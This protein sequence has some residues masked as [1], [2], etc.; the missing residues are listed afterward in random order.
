M[1]AKEVRP[2]DARAQT[3]P[4][5]QPLGTLSDGLV[6]QPKKTSVSEPET[7]GCR[8]L[9]DEFEQAHSVPGT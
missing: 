8:E 4:E 3:V 5:E 9:V 2:G 1:L 6:N 7:E